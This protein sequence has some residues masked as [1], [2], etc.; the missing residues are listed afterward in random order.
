MSYHKKPVISVSNGLTNS[1]LSAFELTKTI[2]NVSTMSV[3]IT[4]LFL[5]NILIKLFQL[6]YIRPSRGLEVNRSLERSL[7]PSFSEDSIKAFTSLQSLYNIDVPKSL[8]VPLI[9]VDVKKI[10]LYGAS[11]AVETYIARVKHFGDQESYIQDIL[12]QYPSYNPIV[13]IELDFQEN[14]F[15]LDDVK[16]SLKKSLDVFNIAKIIGDALDKNQKQLASVVLK[17]NVLGLQIGD[18]SIK[19]RDLLQEKDALHEKS[20]PEKAP[21]FHAP[22][23]QI[24]DRDPKWNLPSQIEAL[25]STLQNNQALTAKVKN[26]SK[27]IESYYRQLQKP[28]YNSYHAFF[29]FHYFLQVLFRLF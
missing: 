9:A 2:T 19:I 8:H 26:I 5:S 1:D 21:M 27:T 16:N 24:E 23:P 18:I 20:I 6:L 10:L 29:V 17:P 22:Q 13:E 3:K 14:R 12:S 25:M 11:V 15:T 28:T 7:P 4:Q